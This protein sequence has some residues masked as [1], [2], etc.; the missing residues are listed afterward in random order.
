MSPRTKEVNEALTKYA[1]VVDQQVAKQLDE[2]EK[3]VGGRQRL[4]NAL[5][6]SGSPT[7]QRTAKLL[8]KAESQKLPLLEAI[9]AAKSDVNE[10]INAFSKGSLVESTVKTIARLSDGMPAIMDESIAA[11]LAP[12]GFKDREMLFKISGILDTKPMVQLNLQQN[13]GSFGSPGVFEQVIRGGSAAQFDD[14]FAEVIDV[15]PEPSDV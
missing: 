1:D 10:V 4:I 9:R 11:A 15:E 3:S 14:P 13:L 5:I 8:Q 7:A 6:L 12:D 2:L